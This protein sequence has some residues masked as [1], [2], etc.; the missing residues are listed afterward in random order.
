VS[1]SSSPA[2]RVRRQRLADQLVGDVERREVVG[3]AGRAREARVERR[4]V[5]VVDAQL[6]RATQQSHRAVAVRRGVPVVAQQ[7]LGAQPD[8]VHDVPGELDVEVRS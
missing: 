3:R 5:E 6:D 7:P 4:G 8:A 1:A 2:D